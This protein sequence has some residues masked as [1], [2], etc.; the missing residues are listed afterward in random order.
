MLQH[1]RASVGQEERAL[2]GHQLAMVLGYRTLPLAILHLLHGLGK[3]H[4]APPPS[5]GQLREQRDPCGGSSNKR[6]SQ[7]KNVRFALAQLLGTCGVSYFWVPHRVSSWLSGGGIQALAG[8]I[9][10]VLDI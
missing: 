2:A 9:K 10:L 5:S 6:R 1:K 8:R 3:S 4:P 7:I